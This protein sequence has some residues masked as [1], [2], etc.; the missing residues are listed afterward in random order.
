M[1]LWVVEYLAEY[2]NGENVNHSVSFAPFPPMM[3]SK[4]YF[5]PGREAQHY[6]S[7]AEDLRL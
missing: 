3:F 1:N 7:I 6:V 2:L 5:G 4:L